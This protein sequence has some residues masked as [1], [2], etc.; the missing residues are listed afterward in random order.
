MGDRTIVEQA[1]MRLDGRRVRSR[2]LA[3]KR[4][5]YCRVLKCADELAKRIRSARNGILREVNQHVGVSH[6]ERGRLARTAV[7]ER[8]SR[9]LND[10]ESGIAGTVGCAVRRRG[11]DHKNIV[12]RK[13]LASNCVA[14][15]LPVRGCI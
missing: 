9:N 10:S 3:A 1:S 7:I 5:A 15:P 2:N 14:K 8:G 4:G 13:T 6:K 12:R 11:V